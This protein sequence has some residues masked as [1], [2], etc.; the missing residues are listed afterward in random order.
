MDCKVDLVKKRRFGAK[1]MKFKCK[2][3]TKEN[4]KVIWTLND[5]NIEGYP[6]FYVTHKYK[7]KHN[8]VISV[9]EILNPKV[10]Y[11]WVTV[12]CQMKKLGHSF[13][14]FGGWLNNFQRLISSLSLV[15]FTKVIFFNH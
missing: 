14:S 7:K 8:L 9:M 15:I 4:N 13:P 10:L 11:F 6:E 5:K 3:K 1:R 2:F 12:R